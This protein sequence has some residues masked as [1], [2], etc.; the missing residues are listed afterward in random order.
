MKISFIPQTEFA[1]DCL[2]P[3]LPAKQ[4]LPQWYKDTPFFIEGM[5]QY[6]HH[7][8]NAPPTTVKGCNPFMDALISGYVYCLSSDLE[9]VN[10]GSDNYS[11]Y[12]RTPNQVITHHTKAQHPLLPSPFQG[13][14]SVFKFH[15]DFTIKTPK[16]YSTFFTHPTNQHDLPFRTLSG[17]VDTDTYM[18]PIHFPFQLLSLD[19]DVIILEKGTPVC[20]FIPFKRD[21]WKHEVQKYDEKLVEKESFKYRSRLYRAYKSLHWVKKKFN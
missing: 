12:W 16:G 8:C 2:T 10:E 18:P 5:S 1:A 13:S 6:V 17:I 14:E 20:Q 19:K 21:H 9:I 3:P 15:N 4:V 11:F 7:P